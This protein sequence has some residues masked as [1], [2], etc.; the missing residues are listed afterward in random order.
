MPG[1]I[2]LEVTEGPI[3]GKV[4]TFDEHDTFIFGRDSDC[5]AQLSDDDCTASR[6]HFMLEV[7][8]PD[9]CI[10]DLGSLNGTY[11]NGVKHG[12]REGHETPEEAA[13]RRFPEMDI[14]DGDKIEVGETV[15]LV[16]VD[17]P[18]NCAA[19]GVSIPESFKIACRNVA[20]A[21]TCPQCVENEKKGLAPSK[22]PQ[23]IR[24]KQCGKDVSDEV[25]RGRSGDYIC[26]PA[27][28][29]WHLTRYRGS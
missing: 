1:K 14:K 9:A 15:F 23:P 4:F 12:G 24:C 19:C 16:T 20:G 7:N 3:K 18:A 17:L 27:G 25:A 10:R 21:Y 13:C 11:V 28:K 6:H 2:I 26:G 29:R 5:H 8:P 22:A